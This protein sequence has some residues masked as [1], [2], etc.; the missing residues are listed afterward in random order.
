M[1]KQQAK[2]GASSQHHMSPDE[3]PAP[4]VHTHAGRREVPEMSTGQLWKIYFE[5]QTARKE[6]T[7][8]TAQSVERIALKALKDLR[9]HHDKQDKHDEEVASA[10][11]DEM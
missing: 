5:A 9:Y 11:L 1:S 6:R 2:R 8:K 7:A 10:A 4:P 3:S